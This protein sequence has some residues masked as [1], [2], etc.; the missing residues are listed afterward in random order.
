[1]LSTLRAFWKNLKFLKIEFW[2]VMD[3]RAEND[4]RLHRKV[5]FPAAPVGETFWPLGIQA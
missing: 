3:V 5:R 2:G 1:M 4:R